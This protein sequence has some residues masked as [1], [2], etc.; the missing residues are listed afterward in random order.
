M[1]MRDL[2]RWSTSTRFLGIFQEGTSDY[3]NPIRADASNVLSKD[4]PETL[5]RA[6]VMT[7]LPAASFPMCSFMSLRHCCLPARQRLNWP[8]QI[9]KTS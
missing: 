4:S 6:W 7:I 2:R 1:R 3:G 8:S 9:R 5:L